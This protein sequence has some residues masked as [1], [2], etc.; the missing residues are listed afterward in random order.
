VEEACRQHSLSRELI[1]KVLK[2]PV[3]QHQYDSIM[4]ATY[5]GGNRNLLPLAAAVNAGQADQIPDILPSLDTNKKGEHKEGLKMRRRL[6]AKIAKNGDY[7]QLFPIPM[8][9]GNPRK[10]ERF[11]YTPTADELELLDA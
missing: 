3:T 2:K 8:Y 7:G 10:T 4:E 9:K 6:S 1:N 5:Q 11:W